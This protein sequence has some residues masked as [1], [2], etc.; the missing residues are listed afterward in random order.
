M[1]F[2]ATALLNC[3]CVLSGEYHSRLLMAAN[4]AY[5]WIVFLGV[6]AQ[7]QGWQGVLHRKSRCDWSLFQ[8]GL[9]FLDELLNRCLEIPAVLSP[10]PFNLSKSVR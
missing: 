5:L 8:L 7:R 3:L 2:D 10:P 9:A 6:T 4:L 1:R